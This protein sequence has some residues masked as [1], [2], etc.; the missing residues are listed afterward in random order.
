MLCI[1]ANGTIAGVA[2]VATKVTFTLFGM[3]LNTGTGIETYKPLVQ[4]QFSNAA[5]TIYTATANGPTFVKTISVVNTDTVA[6]TFQI[7]VGGTAATNQVTGTISLSPG[8]FATY[9]DGSAAGWQVFSGTAYA[10][11]HPGVMGSSGCKGATFDRTLV[12]EVN[13]TITTTG[14][15]YME[16]VWLPAG[17]VVSS[18]RMWSATTAA[19]TPTHYNM[20]LYDTSGNRLATGTD[21][22][23]TA[24]NA[25]T[26]GSFTMQ[27]P[28]TI[29]TSGLYYIAFSMVA[30]TVITVKG[31]TAKTAS[32]IEVASLPISGVS[33]TAYT[34]GDMPATL[35]VPSAGVTTSLYAE[36]A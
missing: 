10:G 4:G 17:T 31:T 7:F 32:V 9:E 5:A 26:L 19:G 16:L 21:K 13:T 22:T 1:A 14:Q 11:Y 25:N 6:H 24:W 8:A 15:V 2:D 33:A 12:M 36:V 18:I 20:G 23:S 30:T 35:A 34:T 27:S 3:E 29:P 28:Y